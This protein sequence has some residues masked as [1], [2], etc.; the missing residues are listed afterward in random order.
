[1]ETAIS[2]AVSEHEK[3]IVGDRDRYGDGVV[4]LRAE[5]FYPKCHVYAS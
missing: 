5:H 2:C 1:M 3:R 4:A